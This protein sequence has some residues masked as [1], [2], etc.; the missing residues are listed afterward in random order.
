MMRNLKSN[1]RLV[2]LLCLVS[3]LLGSST[4]VKEK[5][6]FFENGKL[7]FGSDKESGALLVFEDV[8]NTHEYFK[9]NISP[10]SNLI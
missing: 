8:L 7:K 3:F 9:K 2:L 10:F 5:N 4:Y 6:I 1:I